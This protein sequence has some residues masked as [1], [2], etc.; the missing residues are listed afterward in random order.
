[1]LG[2]G[3]TYVDLENNKIAQYVHKDS[4]PLNNRHDELAIP[5]VVQLSTGIPYS[6]FVSKKEQVLTPLNVEYPWPVCE[7][8]AWY[9]KYNNFDDELASIPCSDI[10]QKDL[11]WLVLLQHPS[12][13]TYYYCVWM[14][15][16]EL[17]PNMYNNT[18]EFSNP[19]LEFEMTARAR[20]RKQRS[21]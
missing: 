19:R 12:Q 17:I 10:Y 15:W 6:L 11:I 21:I 14:D 16:K 13:K 8:D 3:N 4:D 5:I 7:F 1:M 9:F 18:Y 2:E 20:Q